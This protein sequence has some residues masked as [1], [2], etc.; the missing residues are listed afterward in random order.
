MSRKDDVQRLVAIQQRRLQIL[1][2]QRAKFG[3]STPPHIAIEIEDLE[4]EINKL[5]AELTVSESAYGP[6]N[7]ALHERLRELEGPLA[8]YNRR[9]QALQ[10]DLAMELDSERRAV[11]EERL[12]EVKSQGDR[13]QSELESIKQQLNQ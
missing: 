7:A 11:L 10:K 3:I 2:E 4:Q 6:S 12:Q 1:K 9:A 5:Q 13:L 8:T